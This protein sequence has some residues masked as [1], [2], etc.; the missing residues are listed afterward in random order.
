MGQLVLPPPRVKAAAGR[1]EMILETRKPMVC[2]LSWN[3]RKVGHPTPSCLSFDMLGH[4]KLLCSRW[5]SPS[6]VPNLVRTCCSSETL[7]L[8]PDLSAINRYGEYG[9][10]GNLKYAYV[11]KVPPSVTAEFAQMDHLLSNLHVSDVKNLF[12]FQ[13]NLFNE[14]AHMSII[15]MLC[16]GTP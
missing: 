11:G 1:W 2:G 12:W 15:L 4:L 9:N 16:Q 6:R 8:S 3:F 13:L 10:P 14:G 7:G 5:R